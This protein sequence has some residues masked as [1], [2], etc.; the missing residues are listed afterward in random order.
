MM[1]SCFGVR[2]GFRVG[3]G[4]MAGILAAWLV[5]ALAHHPMGGAT[6]VTVWQGVLSGIGHPVIEIDHLVFLLAAGALAG[7]GAGSTAR[8]ALVL[9]GSFALASMA[10]T[11]LRVPGSVVPMA[12]ALVPLS[13]LAV[14]ICL[15]IGR[16]PQGRM[17]LGLAVLAGAAHGYAFGEAVIG[18]EPTPVF[19]YL[20]GLALT[21]TLLMIAAF[22]IAKAWRHRAPS[23]LPWATRLA[24]L[25]TAATAVA[26]MVG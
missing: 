24:A 20:A 19:G 5:P 25:A 3:R 6:P 12:E 10:G 26:T 16:L 21:Q 8:R 18:A 23:A 11:V 13:L 2:F 1:A 7:A 22:A 4:L 9:A 15:A 17:A 14:A